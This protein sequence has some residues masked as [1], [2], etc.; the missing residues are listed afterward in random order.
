MLYNFG[1]DKLKKDKMYDTENRVCL[2]HNENTIMN[3]KI[4]GR[5]YYMESVHLVDIYCWILWHNNTQILYNKRESKLM[6]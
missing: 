6:I 1:K 4:D 2:F 5:V 3:C